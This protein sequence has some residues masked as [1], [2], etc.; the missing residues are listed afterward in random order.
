MEF[1]ETLNKLAELA[2]GRVK[3]EEF[4]SADS[5]RLLDLFVNNEA[6]LLKMYE[7][8]FPQQSFKAKQT[9]KNPSDMIKLNE[10][11]WVGLHPFNDSITEATGQGLSANHSH[12]LFN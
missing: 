1:E 3:F 11:S 12:M 8:I 9:L 5:C 7:L 10:T 6:T 4:T 2:K